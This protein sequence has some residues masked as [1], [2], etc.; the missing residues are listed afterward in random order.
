MTNTNPLPLSRPLAGF[1]LAASIVFTALAITPAD[2]ST[3]VNESYFR[4]S[5]AGMLNVC[6]ERNA[7]VHC[8]KSVTDCSCD[9]GRFVWRY[10]SSTAGQQ[11]IVIRTPSPKR[12]SA[13]AFGGEGGLGGGGR[14]GRGGKP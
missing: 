10:R 2:A 11:P 8:P 12:F 6:S 5:K 4:M 13:S 1:A 7:A 3:R 14:G 9:D